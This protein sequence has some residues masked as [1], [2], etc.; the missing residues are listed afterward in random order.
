MNFSNPFFM[1]D[2]K[3]IS[4]RL[5]EIR[6]FTNG[7]IIVLMGVNRDKIDFV[8]FGQDGPKTVIREIFSFHEVKNAKT[9]D[10]RLKIAVN[11]IKKI[12]KEYYI[13]KD[14]VNLIFFGKC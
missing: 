6:N 2:V 9:L 5:V 13:E 4:D 1:V 8:Y 14:V 3:I 11:A 7:F 12:D 10:E